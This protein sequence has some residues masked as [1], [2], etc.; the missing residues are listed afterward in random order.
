[1][2]MFSQSNL[3]LFAFFAEKLYE[4]LN[5]QLESD[6]NLKRSKLCLFSLLYF[7][8]TFYLLYMIAFGVICMQL[9]SA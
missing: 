1:M 9:S 4:F 6:L 5:I 7:E 3:S 8:D 2:C